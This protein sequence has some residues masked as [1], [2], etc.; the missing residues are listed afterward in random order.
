MKTLED[1]IDKI[2]ADF[3]P[4]ALHHFGD[5]LQSIL[6]YGSAAAG[7][8][9]KESSDINLLLLLKT[10]DPKALI[11]LGKKQD[12]LIRRLRLSLQIL[13]TGE[14]LKSGDIFPLEYGDLLINRQ[15]LWGQDPCGQ[16]SIEEQ[17]LR[18]QVESLLRGSVNHLRQLLLAASGREKV[19]K[20]VL[21]EWFGAQTALWRGLIRLQGR[22]L[23]HSLE[24]QSKQISA[25]YGTDTTPL[26]DLLHLKTGE[27]AGKPSEVATALMGCLTD[28]TEKVDAMD[29]RYGDPA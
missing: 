14:F 5:N 28:L 29:S 22:D 16:L 20:E 23:P 11:L 26:Q 1:H 15:L 10:P 17:H 25:L 2:K 12:R 18:H 13:T 19:F 7:T 27:S 6:L 8:W 21:V 4:A 24:E 9:Q 3:C